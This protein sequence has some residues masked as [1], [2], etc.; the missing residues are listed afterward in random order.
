MVEGSYE[1]RTIRDPEVRALFDRD[2]V[3][4]SDWYGARLEAQ[5]EV[6]RRLW[7]R[8]VAYLEGFLRQPIYA[9]EFGRL[10][11]EDKLRRAREA[12]AEAEND[13]RTDR[14]RGTLGV[15]PPL[16]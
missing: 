10:E 1:G 15:D 3:L 11:I 4:N 6:D 8:H 5:V 2:A 12:L 9:A 13:G 7:A 16:V 14:I